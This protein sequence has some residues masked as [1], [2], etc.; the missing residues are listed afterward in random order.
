MKSSYAATLFVV[1]FFSAALLPLS[2][3]AAPADPVRAGCGDYRL[4]VTVETDALGVGVRVSGPPNVVDVVW[5]LSGPGLGVELDAAPRVFNEDNREIFG[6][7]AN[8]AHEPIEAAFVLLVSGVQAGQRLQLEMGHEGAGPLGTWVKVSNARDDVPGEEL[9]RFQVTSEYQAVSVDLCASAPMPPLEPTPAPLPPRVLAFFY[10]WWGTVAEPQGPYTCSGDAFGWVREVEGQVRFV[11]A[12]TPIFQD[13]ERTIYTQTACWMQW[14]DDTGRSGWL[15]DVSEVNFL[16]EQMQ[17][18]RQNGI[19]G[20]LVSVH[21][22]NTY[23]MDYLQ[24]IAL[25][26]AAQADFLVGALYERPE[27]AE[28]GGWSFDEATD[29]ALVGGHLRRLVEMLAQSPAALRLEDAQGVEKVVIFVDPA[30]V[31]RFTTPEQWAAIRALVDE[32]GIPYALWGGPAAFTQVFLGGFDGVF[33]DLEVIETYEPA[34]GLPPYALRDER[35]LAYRATAWTARELGMYYALPVVLGW[36]PSPV[37]PQE[38]SIPRD[39][40]FP[41]DDGAYYRVRWED[42]T[43]NDPHW[44]VITS[45]NEWAEATEIEPSDVYPP[46]RYDYL[47]ATA[48]YACRWRTPQAACEG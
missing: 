27:G 36:G 39:Y 45:W 19:D 21:G 26:T 6:V 44:V 35:R 48:R 43:E 37:H 4:I 3:R 32:A 41:G 22:D 31:A 5:N 17:L 42:A 13:G 38:T 33:N 1:A 10:P 24:N 12:H 7:E 20:F 8:E 30:V 23:E 18:A 16:A 25:P 9:A 46:S 34:L 14:T 15:Y 28:F 11:T 2:A 40:G 47:G 29:I